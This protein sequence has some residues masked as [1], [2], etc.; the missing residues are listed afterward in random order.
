M[1]LPAEANGFV[2]SADWKQQTQGTPWF[3]GDTY[4]LS[5]GQGDLLVTPLQV[6]EFT[7]TVAMGG[8]KPTPHVLMSYGDASSTAAWPMSE[9]VADVS[10]I[11]TV[12]LGMRDCVTYGSG[13]ALASFPVPVAG[14]TGTAQ[15][16]NDKPNQAWFTAFAPFDDPQV[17]VTVLIEEGGEGSSVAVPVARD[18]LQAWL[19]G[20]KDLTGR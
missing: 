3:I 7:A 19:D 15:W 11:Q 9:P 5:I 6:A 14:K 16:R 10:I 18:V 4:N 13:R 12:R 8:K 17:V 1:D 2:P 20:Q